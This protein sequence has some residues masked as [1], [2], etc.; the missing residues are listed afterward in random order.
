MFSIFF[1]RSF[2]R[3]SAAAVC[4]VFFN[5]LSLAQPSQAVQ[6]QFNAFVAEQPFE[7]GKSYPQVGRPEQTITPTDWRMFISDIAL[8]DAYGQWIPLQLTP[9]GV[10]QNSQLAL[11]DFENGKGPCRNGTTGLNQTAK[12][13]VPA[14]IYSGIKFQIGV[15]FDQNHGDPTTANPPLSTTAMFWNWQGGYKFIKFDALTATSDTPRSSPQRSAFAFHLGSTQCSSTAQTQPPMKAC[16]KTN[17]VQVELVGE[18]PIS[19]P[20]VFDMATLLRGANVANNT[21][22]TPPGC[23]STSSDP[24][25]T[26]IFRHLN[27]L[28]PTSESLQPGFVRWGK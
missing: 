26:E 20:V 11:L 19:T 15:P 23:M 4:L 21:P 17:A 7:C 5:T 22:N 3:I 13:Q 28:V 16:Q 8:R 25:C 1:A 24:D 27:L 2:L 10:W 18:N 12:G 14:K 9:D 6:I